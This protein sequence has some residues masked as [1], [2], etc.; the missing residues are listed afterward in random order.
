MT[1]TTEKEN[2]MV[3]VVIDF[4]GYEKPAV[5]SVLRGLFSDY[6][7]SFE[8]IRFERDTTEQNRWY[9]EFYLRVCDVKRL[10]V[11]LREV[12]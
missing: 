7:R 3:R 9:T 11:L 12:S 1:M 4:L 5:A 10:N 2:R 6:R 8:S